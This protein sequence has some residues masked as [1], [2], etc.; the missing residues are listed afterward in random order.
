MKRFRGVAQPGVVMF[1]LAIWILACSDDDPQRAK[2][3]HLDGEFDGRAAH[4]HQDAF[5]YLSGARAS[6]E[7][8]KMKAEGSI[9]YP[10]GTTDLDGG[11]KHVYWEDGFDVKQN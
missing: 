2:E 6:G 4:W 9:I 10:M 3:D 1:A 5:T 11:W 7:M 8:K